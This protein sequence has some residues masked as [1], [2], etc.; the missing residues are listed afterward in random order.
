MKIGFQSSKYNE[1]TLEDELNFTIK[2]NADFFDIFFDE[3]F[4]FDI[5]AKE[6][7]KISDFQRKGFS[8]TVHLPIST[9]NLPIEKINCLLDF[10]FTSD[11]CEIYTK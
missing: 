3:W 7:K 8:F 5:S 4:P 11:I 2:E 1:L 6:F 9:P 10:I